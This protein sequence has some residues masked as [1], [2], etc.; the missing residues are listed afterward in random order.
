MGAQAKKNISESGPQAAGLRVPAP[1]G[2]EHQPRARRRTK[3][4]TE[5]PG[6]GTHTRRQSRP[7]HQAPPDRG[8]RGGRGP[9]TRGR[10]NPQ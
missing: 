7:R 3:N 4:K 1:A 9:P 5:R 8:A 10:T 2:A 6:P